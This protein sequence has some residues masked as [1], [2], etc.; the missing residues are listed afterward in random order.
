MPNVFRRVRIR[1]KLDANHHY[2]GRPHVGTI[3]GDDYAVY[4]IYSRLAIILSTSSCVILANGSYMRVKGGNLSTHCR[5]GVTV[6]RNGRV[7][8][9]N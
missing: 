5:S 9:D 7:M 3:T 1:V 8:I 2:N 4:T 6:L